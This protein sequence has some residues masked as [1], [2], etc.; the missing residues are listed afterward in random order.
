[1]DLTVRMGSNPIPGAKILGSFREAHAKQIFISVTPVDLNLVRPRQKKKSLH[2][3]HLFVIKKRVLSTN[4]I[5][6]A[7][8]EDFQEG[9]K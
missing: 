4:V 5:F 9:K 6:G 3:F 7:I 8:I 2:S 1:M